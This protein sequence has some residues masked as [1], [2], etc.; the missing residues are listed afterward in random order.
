[1]ALSRFFFKRW[2]FSSN[3]YNSKRKKT[4]VALN[5][6]FDCF[7]TPLLISRFASFVASGEHILEEEVKIYENDPTPWLTSDSD[8]NNSDPNNDLW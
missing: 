5:F 8:G 1:M 6:A 3:S 4:S 7:V 2:H